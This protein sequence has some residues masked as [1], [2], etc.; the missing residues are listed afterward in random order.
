MNGRR[1]E[2]LIDLQKIKAQKQKKITEIF[3]DL[4]EWMFIYLQTET[5]LREKVRAKQLFRHKL[6]LNKE[7]VL[8]NELQIHLEHWLLL[9][10]VTVSG[11]RLLDI[12]VR[13]KQEKMSKDMLELCGILMLM[14][15]EPVK[16]I[17][18]EEEVVTYVS[19]LGDRTDRLQASPFL[20]GVDVSPE[21][22]VLIRIATIG[23]E[24][25]IIGPSIVI[26]PSFEVK[27]AGVFKDVHTQGY[28][29]WR[30]YLKE[31]GIDMLKYR[32]KA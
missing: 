26:D 22:I 23:F 29:V 11:S 7:E 6:G 19:L 2:F 12:F 25:K 24:K 3:A 15:L 9:D 21:Q 30:R 18:V 20:F 28:H 10:Y 17:S 8:D 14:H 31:Y 4:Y 5:N 16:V 27:V 13:T 1:A 32:K